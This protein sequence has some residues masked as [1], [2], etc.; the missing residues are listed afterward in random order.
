MNAPVPPIARDTRVESI[1]KLAVM[2]VGGQG[3]GV[4]N[5]WIVDLAERNG[6]AVQATSVAGVAQR[7]G[8]TIYY[9]EMLPDTGTPPVFALAPA[10]GDVDILI[11]AELM[12]AGRAILRGFVTPERTTLIASTHRNLATLEKVAPGDGRGDPSEVRKAAAIAAREFIAFDMEAMA[13]ASGS[14]ISASLFG[15]LAGSGALPFPAESYRD[16]IRASGRG[17][18]A[19]L[20]AFELARTAAEARVQ[21]TAPDPGPNTASAPAPDPGPPAPRLTGPETL[22]A[23]YAALEARLARLPPEAQHIARAGLRKVVDFQD[24]AYGAEYLDLLEALAAKDRN[25]GGAQHAHAF[26]QAAAKYLANAMAY[27]DL[28]HVADHKT[29]VARM[30]RIAAE[31]AARPE[32]LVQ[33]TEYLH[34]GAPEFVSLMPARL[35][36]FVESRPS[37]M[38][39]LDR[40]V[41]RGRR[42]RTDRLPSFLLLYAVAGLRRWRRSLLRHRRERAHM[43]AWLDTATTRLPKNYEHAVE[44]LKIRRLVKGYSDTHARGLSKFDRAMAGAQLVEGRDDAAQWTARLI[45]AALADPAG[46]ALDGALDTIRSF[47]T[48]GRA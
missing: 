31:L 21:D 46:T 40:L 34:P 44:T 8:A 9:V 41:N 36:A 32:T 19:S 33:V 28:P 13:L 37:L 29:R 2:A 38:R 1:V 39:A 18:E 45:A 20:A 14:V 48:Q 42:M 4:L 24:T 26:T 11:A 27:D 22:R 35:G 5:G 7:T 47:T 43:A 3:G 17:A 25:A 6:Y 16:C 12:E 10:E 23:A 30:P 15:A